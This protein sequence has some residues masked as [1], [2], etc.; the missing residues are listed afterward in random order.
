IPP[1]PIEWLVV[2]SNPATILETTPGNEQIFQKI[3]HVNL[4]KEKLLELEAKYTTSII[5]KSDSKRLNR[6]LLK[7]NTPYLTNILQKYEIPQI[8]IKT[9]TRCAIC[10]FVPMLRVPA[11]WFCPN[12][13]HYS[14][15][16]HIASLY[17]YFLINQSTITNR[18]CR[19]F[20]HIPT[21]SIAL[22][23]LSGLPLIGTKGGSAY[24]LSGL[25][26]SPNEYFLL[27]KNKL[28]DQN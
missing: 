1:I 16:A 11:N 17:D 5:N 23:L 10:N 26:R 9:G 6:L 24:E 21:R 20:L 3:I 4:L 7:E 12:C 13:N 25:L 22:G 15:N 28:W 19:E 2:F 14:K 27:P 8:D 18:Q